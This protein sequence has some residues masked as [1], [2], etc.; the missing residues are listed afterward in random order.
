MNEP[1]NQKLASLSRLF[2]VKIAECVY[3]NR[4]PS[5][6]PDLCKDDAWF[7]IQT[8]TSKQLRQA[9]T[10]KSVYGWFSVD[11]SITNPATV[12]ERWYI[13]HLPITKQEQISNI[14]GSSTEIKNSVYREMSQV[15]R[16]I[17]SIMNCLPAKF[18]ENALKNIPMCN[19][20]VS[21]LYKP[22]NP[23]PAVNNAFTELETAQLRFGPIITPVGRT[24][25]FCHYRISLESEIPRP[26]RTA[27]H[28]SLTVIN[29]ESPSQPIFGKSY[30]YSQRQ[31]QYFT[32][33]PT[34]SDLSCSHASYD[35]SSLEEFILQL[36]SSKNVKYDPPKSHLTLKERF[37]KI[38][39]F[40]M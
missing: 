31:S 16:S 35:V 27:E 18:I 14:S 37:Q 11:V 5:S 8:L 28:Y 29:D 7:S 10:S 22:F 33:T 40:L 9:L 38:S 17:F 19:R 24:V 21:A 26:V 12:I 1:E 4:D 36:K 20:K 3:Q 30:E 25:V 2:M 32:N 34:F 6:L 13:I 23:L 15:L 39:N